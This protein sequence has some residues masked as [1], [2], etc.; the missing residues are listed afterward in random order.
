[1]P[2][3]SA[4]PAV[5]AVLW[6]MDGVLVDSGPYHY[7]SWQMAFA[8][9][10]LSFG[11]EDFWRT[12]GQ[13]ND[14][15]IADVVGPDLPREQA[16]AIAESKERHYRQIV[17]REG[18]A[19]LPG[20]RPWLERLHRRGLPQ[21]VVSS[22]PP[23]NLAVVLEAIGA[24]PFFQ[25]LVSGS[26]VTRGKPDPEPFLLAARRLGVPPARCIVV[27]D[28]PAGLEAARRAGMA[29]LAL[30]TSHPRGELS[31]DGVVDSLDGLPEDALDR[32]LAGS[33]A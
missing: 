5:F 11:E 7:R 25:A 18:I 33:A 32:L 29:C 21:A 9:R 19:A 28:A 23:E 2:E 10:G 3:P 15:I 12:F 17:R 26:D 22:A 16:E 27:E 14:S 20:V 6:D 4:R 1:M 24:A 13:R 31:A 30:T 8:E